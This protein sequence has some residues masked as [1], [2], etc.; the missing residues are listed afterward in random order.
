[1]LSSSSGELGGS[2][3]HTLL[4]RQTNPLVFKKTPGESRCYAGEKFHLLVAL[5]DTCRDTYASPGK[6][7]SLFLV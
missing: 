3:S 5:Y 1:M 4:D 2:I 7:E 6:I